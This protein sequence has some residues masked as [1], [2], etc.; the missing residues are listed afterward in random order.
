MVTTTGSVV[1]LVSRSGPVT[2][3]V[4]SEIGMTALL[5]PS[6]TVNTAINLMYCPNAVVHAKNSQQIYQAVNMEIE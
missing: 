1:I 4:H 3:V 2:E 5:C 6:Y